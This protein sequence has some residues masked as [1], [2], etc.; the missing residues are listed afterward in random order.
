MMKV[1][2]SGV[3]EWFS[4]HPNPESR[5]AAMKIAAKKLMPIYEASL[6]AQSKPPEPAPANAAS[7]F[8]QSL[9]KSA[10]LTATKS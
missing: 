8:G 2:G 4:T 10:K 1:S 5:I 7:G 6:K 9:K 3:P